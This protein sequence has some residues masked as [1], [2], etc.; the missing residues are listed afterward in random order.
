MHFTTYET[1]NK[2][3]D[4]FYIGVHSTN[5]IFDS[6]LGS[7]SHFTNALKTYGRNNF[8]KLITGVWKSEDIMYLMEEWLVDESVVVDPKSYN[9]IPG[10]RGAIC[11]PKN[12]MVT[13]FD[14]SLNIFVSI[15]KSQINNRYVGVNSGKIRVHN[16]ITEKVVC[17][18]NIP[19][20]FIPGRL[21]GIFDNAHPQSRRNKQSKKVSGI[22]NGNS[23]KIDFFNENNQLMFSAHGNLGEV[24][25]KNN[26]SRDAV[27][28]SLRTGNSMY[29]KPS[30][31][32]L[33]SGRDKFIGWIVRYH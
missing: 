13:A 19:K 2:V 17:V 3:N 6:Y 11:K 1:T 32:L 30:K 22:S 16:H 10:G 14:K 8:H 25:T 5:N 18:N 33:K 15:L 12:G 23:K 24:I 9:Q 4:K 28:C 27:M 31:K 7:G 21:S 26:L 20:G 29:P